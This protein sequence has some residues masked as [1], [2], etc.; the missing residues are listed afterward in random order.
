LFVSRSDLDRRSVCV[1]EFQERHALFTE[2]HGWV[3]SN[4]ITQMS[5]GPS[6]IHSG[7]MAYEASM[8]LDPVLIDR[9]PEP[10]PLDGSGH[11]HRNS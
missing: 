3:I 5:V 7:S 1:C 9:H 2:V 4:Y 8:T 6:K 10:R 11:E